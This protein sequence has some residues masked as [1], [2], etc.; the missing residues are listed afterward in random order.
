VLSDQKSDA[1]IIHLCDAINELK[2]F[3]LPRRAHD[4]YHERHATESKLKNHVEA[5]TGRHEDA[6]PSGGLTP[7][8]C[9]SLREYGRLPTAF[10]QR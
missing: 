9:C 6:T 3:H 1:R 7:S 10:Q 4:P 5:L 2:K 8:G